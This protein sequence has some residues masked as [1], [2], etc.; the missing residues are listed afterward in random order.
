MSVFSFPDF[1][2]HEK[3]LFGSDSKSGLKAV[4]A[5]HNTNLGPAVGGCRMYNYENEDQALSDVLRL[6]QGMTYKSALAGLPLGGGKSVIIGDP[7]VHKSRDLLEAMARLVDSLEGG[8]IAAQDSGTS[9]EDLK[10]MAR[11][12]PHIAGA[13][14]AI[15]T[16]GRQRTGDPSPATAYGV[17]VGLKAAV[18]HKLGKDNLRGVRVAIQGVGNVGFGLGK[19]LHDE[20]AS[21]VVSDV[22]ADN[23]KKAQSELDAT[24][25][26]GDAIYSQDVDVF[27]PCALGG[28]I[29]E[30]S[31]DLI[32]APV[33]AGGANNQLV[34]TEMGKKLHAR[35]TLYAPD[36]VINA[37]GIIHVHYMRTGKS[38]QA[39][40]EHVS[41]IGNTL[42]EIFKR[43][44]AQNLCTSEIANQLAEERFLKR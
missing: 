29:N 6:S 9:V 8:Y 19:W 2:D 35:G 41:C 37:G 39:S 3:V 21:L 27:A 23:L 11:I 16:T 40:T 30:K 28:A 15:D 42:S 44:D 32:T 43:S 20:G 33:I 36:F 10:V 38:W 14:G 17:F 12:T 24:I 25:V 26:E 22:N 1:A 4:I 18:K 13:E 5:V 7:K 31:F 34:D